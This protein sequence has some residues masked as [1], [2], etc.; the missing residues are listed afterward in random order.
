MKTMN[1]TDPSVKNNLFLN[2]HF[3]NFL[4]YSLYFLFL[5]SL[6]DRFSTSTYHGS[7]L[8]FVDLYLPD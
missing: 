8:K 1:S 7:E 6:L 5:P 2:S 3:L 4:F